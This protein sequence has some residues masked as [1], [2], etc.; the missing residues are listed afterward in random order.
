MNG[1]ELAD[2]LRSREDGDMVTILLMSA[3]APREVSRKKHLKTL[4]KPFEL[5]TL[6]QVVAE[7]LV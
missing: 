5:E 6:L 1:L 2:L 4:Q 7:L 3:D